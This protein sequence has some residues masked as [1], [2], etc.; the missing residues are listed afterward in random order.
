MIYRKT[1]DLVLTYYSLAKLTE[2]IVSIRLNKHMIENNLHSE[3]QYG[4]KRGH[5]TETLL[6]KVVNDLLVVCDE[7][8]PTI[9]MLLDLSAAFDTADQMKL[10]E[11]LQGNIGI[12]GT[13]LK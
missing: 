13:V 12:K 3:F 5:S 6:L 1:T 4:Y 10:L 7:Q 8:K 9:L 2:R 11:I